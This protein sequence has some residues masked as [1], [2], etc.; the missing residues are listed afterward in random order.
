MTRQKFYVLL[1]LSFV[2]PAAVALLA[3]GACG[4][5][6]GDCRLMS[7]FPALFPY[8]YVVGDLLKDNPIFILI[9]LLQ[10]PAY[11]L[12]AQRSNSNSWPRKLLFILLAAHIVTA[13]LGYFLMLQTSG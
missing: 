9:A 1:I 12:L 8:A 6:H 5:G 10:Y 3:I 2:I 11:V 7:A 13:L 4:V